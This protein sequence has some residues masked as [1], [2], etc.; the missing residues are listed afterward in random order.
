MKANLTNIKKIESTFL[1]IEKDF[2]EIIKILFIQN[3]PHSD[4]LKRLLV[5]NTK[6]CMDRTNAYYDKLIRETTVAKLK[7]HGYIRIDPRV[8]QPEHAEIKSYLTFSPEKVLPNPFN[9]HYRDTYFTID[10]LTHCD[11][12]DLGNLQLRPVKIAGYIDALLKDV[13]LS[14][15]GTLEF[16]DLLPQQEAGDYTGYT[17]RYKGIHGV[18]DTLPLEEE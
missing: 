4:E 2:E 5:I 3:Q 16:V 1:S 12:M 13:K 6:D 14:G 7:E 9:P 17:L 10:I 11:Y 15:I 18:D 8:V